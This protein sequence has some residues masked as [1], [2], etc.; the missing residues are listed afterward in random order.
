ML[1]LPLAMVRKR[2]YLE[3]SP[4][5]FPKMLSQI[6]AMIRMLAVYYSLRTWFQPSNLTNLKC[7]SS[8]MVIKIWYIIYNIQSYQRSGREH[9]LWMFNFYLLYFDCLVALSGDICIEI[10]LSNQRSGAST[11]AMKHV[12]NQDPSSLAG[13]AMY[14]ATR[15]YAC[16]IIP[17]C[18][19]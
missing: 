14:H 16:Y 8:R 11:N 13:N 10:R 4:W 1:H 3:C 5:E 12:E 9:N 7:R 15:A 2:R 6:V 17:P 18:H 19:M